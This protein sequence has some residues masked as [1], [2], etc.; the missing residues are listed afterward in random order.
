[1]VV[2][3]TRAKIILFMFV[4]FIAVGQEDLPVEDDDTIEYLAKE[5]M[6]ISEMDIASAF[7]GVLIGKNAENKQK[8]EQET[9]TEISFP[10]RD[11]SGPV[12]IRGRTKAS[13]QSVRTRIELIIERNRQIQSFTHFL[14][15]PIG[16]F[17]SNIKT[18]FDEFKRQ[19]LEQC[20]KERGISNELFQQ[21]S[22]LHLTIGT[23]VLLSK[24]EIDYIKETLVECTQTLLREFMPTNKER[25]IVHLKGLEYMNDDP[26]FVDVLYA[27][28]Q[29]ADDNRTNNRLQIFLD[30]L[31]EELLDTGLM[32]QQQQQPSKHIKLHVT[33][34]NSLL[35]KDQTGILEAQKTARG[36]VKNAERESFDAEKILRLFGT[37]DFGQVELEEM[38]LSIMH[39]P[40]RA[41]GYY[42][43]ESKISL[44]PI[45]NR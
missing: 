2:L 3:D 27:K 29:L 39:E 44:V 35:R 16:Q 40:D 21:A 20:G 36:R 4:L 28:V 42:G 1:M 41:T 6:F 45:P 30:R 22:K 12:I 5:N 17:S 32:K 38:H 34:M 11:N 23:F 25:F 24:S 8:L 19:V 43:C 14:S 10:R 7:Y 31:N 26:N 13:I 9:K 18:K 15:I 37:F 33:L